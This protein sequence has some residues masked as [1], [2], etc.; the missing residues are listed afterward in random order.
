[1]RTPVKY[2]RALVCPHGVEKGR[3]C[4]YCRWSDRSNLAEALA[5]VLA[6]YA[7]SRTWN[8]NAAGTTRV[9][10]R[11]HPD[12]VTPAEFD[13]GRRAREALRRFRASR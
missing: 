13:E 10:K 8:V 12:F 5:R 3:A 9:T 11:R 7:D 1:M 6:F 2:R 4:N